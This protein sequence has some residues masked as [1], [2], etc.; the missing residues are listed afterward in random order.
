MLASIFLPATTISSACCIT[1]TPDTRT[2]VDAHK[3]T[4]QAAAAQGRRFLGTEAHGT[5][6][7]G[8]NN[9]RES[10]PLH[11]CP[12]PVVVACFRAAGSYWRSRRARESYDCR[13]GDLALDYLATGERMNAAMHAV[14]SAIECLC[15]IMEWQC[16]SLEL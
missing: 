1:V 8:R 5:S 12:C 6:Y 16:R 15:R 3:C 4:T 10:A 9:W 13:A 2:V 14:C 7:R 11:S